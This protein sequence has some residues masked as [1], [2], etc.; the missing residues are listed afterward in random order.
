MSKFFDRFGRSRVL[1]PVIHCISE[2]QVARNIGTAL[3]NGA[4]GVFLINQ[5]GMTA[6]AVLKL[7]SWYAEGHGTPRDATAG[8][9]IGMNLLGVELPTVREAFHASRVEGLWVDNAEVDAPL[10]REPKVWPGQLYFGGVA[11]KYQSSVAPERYA[12]LA[13]RARERGVDVLTTSGPA[14][15]V[16]PTL[17]KIQAMADVARHEAL[18]VAI[19]S[20]ITP[21]NVE[22]FLPF[23]HA[24]LVATGIEERFGWLDPARVRT[25]ADAIHSH[26]P[27][28]SKP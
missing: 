27:K 4:D 24:Y 6:D 12:E 1:L 18:E 17:A 5:G 2:E 20:G 10:R 16:P 26:N 13:Q 3:T 7:A 14:T 23:A 28:G 25:L 11:F 15:G 22:P 9:F 8:R 19:A 21:N